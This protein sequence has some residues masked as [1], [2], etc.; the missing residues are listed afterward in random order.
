MHN[1]DTYEKCTKLISVPLEEFNKKYGTT[2]EETKMLGYFGGIFGNWKPDT[3]SKYEE[4]WEVKNKEAFDQFTINHNPYY[5][6]HNRLKI[7]HID[8]HMM[9]GLFR[10]DHDKS[11][12]ISGMPEDAVIRE[13]S[14]QV[15][16]DNI[17]YKIWS[18]TFDIVEEN[19]NIPEM[20]LT[21]T[22]A[23]NPVEDKPV[24]IKSNKINFREFI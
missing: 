8:Q 20:F 15:R 10:L 7:L 5:G 12:S 9:V 1:Q 11:V 18:Q 2:F 22:I 23:G 14:N 6:G 17:T 4:I 24:D 19:C 16:L 13:V 3:K 21:M